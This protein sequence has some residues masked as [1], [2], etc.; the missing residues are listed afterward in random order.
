MI[1]FPLTL[2]LWL[3][4]A[5]SVA[6]P[7]ETF[8]LTCSFTPGRST[9]TAATPTLSNCRSPSSIQPPPSS[10]EVF[11]LLCRRFLHLPTF[12]PLGLKVKGDESHCT[13]FQAQ[14]SY[15][16]CASLWDLCVCVCV[17]LFF[18]LPRFMMKN[19]SIKLDVLHTPAML[20]RNKNF[21]SQKC[22]SFYSY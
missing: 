13:Q 10:S 9:A 3:F 5:A 15:T 11:V 21:A 20:F 8:F 19:L 18:L 6:N 4:S 1:F 2:S 22:I 14:I 7:W 12:S 16:F 17:F